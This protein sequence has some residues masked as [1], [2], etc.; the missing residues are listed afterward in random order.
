MAPESDVDLLFL[1][2]SKKG[3]AHTEA[4]TE[5]ML[6]ML[7][8]LGL[9]VGHSSRTVE[10]CLKLAKEDQTILT[11]LLDMRFLAGDEKLSNDLYAAYRKTVTKGKGRSYIAEKLMERDIRHAKEGNSR[12]VIEPNIKEGKGGLRDLHVLYW[13]TRF[14][15]GAANEATPISDPQFTGCLLYTSPSPRDLSTSRM[16]SSA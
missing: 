16:P 14:L 11:S 4:L 7:W 5:Y 15:G 9:K 2:A 3:S 1:T 8:D 13:I 10:Q 12:Y 6:Y